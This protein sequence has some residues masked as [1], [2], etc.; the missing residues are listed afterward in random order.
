V[1]ADRN[2]LN[3]RAAS[4]YQFCAEIADAASPAKFRNR[5]VY[6]PIPTLHTPALH[7]VKYRCQVSRALVKTAICEETIEGLS[8]PNL[9][10]LAPCLR[11]SVEVYVVANTNLVV[12]AD[13]S[14]GAERLKWLDVPGGYLNGRRF[15]TGSRDRTAL[16][17]NV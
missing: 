9:I 3:F 1:P 13:L 4:T 12:K 8:R 11:L 7:R 6:L 5:T 10:T 14:R 2:G 16:A 17:P 15:A